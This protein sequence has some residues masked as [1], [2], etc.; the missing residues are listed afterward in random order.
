MGDI[1]FSSTSCIAVKY[2]ETLKYCQAVPKYARGAF[3]YHL[4]SQEA[5]ATYAR[6][7]STTEILLTHT[8][9]HGTCDMS[10]KGVLAGCPALAARM[11]SADLD[12]CRLHVFGHIHEAHGVSIDE[13]HQRVNVNAALHHHSQPIIVDLLNHLDNSV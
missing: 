8:P 11:R 9:P 13:E 10:R 7:P 6:I 12:Q 2:R 5:E 1:W 4:G 3:Q